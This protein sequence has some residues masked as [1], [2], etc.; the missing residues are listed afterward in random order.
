MFGKV[1]EFIDSKSKMSIFCKEHDL[2]LSTFRYWHR[3]Y[4][5]SPTDSSKVNSK[6]RFISL[7]VQSQKGAAT[8]INHA[9]FIYP[10]GVRMRIDA[11]SISVLKELVKALD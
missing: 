6:S 3:K 4:L 7:E 1:K 8:S 9:E 2:D 10:N 11:C 5:S